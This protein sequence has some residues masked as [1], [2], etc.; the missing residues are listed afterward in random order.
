[1]LQILIWAVCVLMIGVGYCGKQLAIIAAKEGNKSKAGFGIFWVMVLLAV[2]FAVLAL[3]QGTAL[4]NITSK[5]L[6]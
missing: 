4:S 3:M 1:M 6:P 5:F 2:L